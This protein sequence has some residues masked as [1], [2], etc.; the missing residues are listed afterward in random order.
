MIC[1]QQAAPVPSAQRKAGDVTLRQDSRSTFMSI[2]TNSRT[3]SVEESS[4][5]ATAQETDFFHSTEDLSSP[6]TANLYCCQIH[7]KAKTV[8]AST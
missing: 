2:I 6:A 4:P 1:C 5:P 3:G 8:P 7:L